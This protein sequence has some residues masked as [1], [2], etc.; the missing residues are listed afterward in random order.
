MKSEA[1]YQPV[2]KDI[3]LDACRCMLA[4]LHS[5]EDHVA[6]KKAQINEMMAKV[7]NERFWMGVKYYLF[8]DENGEPRLLEANEDSQKED[9][10]EKAY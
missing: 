7:L 1:E 3:F 2:S 9:W 5:E 6:I 8:L 4:L 10:E